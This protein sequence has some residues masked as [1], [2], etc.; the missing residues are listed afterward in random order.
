MSSAP[1]EVQ[2]SGVSLH[3]L[4]LV[5]V[6]TTTDFTCSLP[7]EAHFRLQFAISG[8]GTTAT[9]DAFAEIDEQRACILPPGQHSELH[10]RGGH[11]RLAL[12]I[13]PDAFKRKLSALMGG[14]PSGELVF[15]PS[16]DMTLE[17]SQSLL[18]TTLVL[19]ENVNWSSS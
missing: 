13:A 1:F 10:L 2:A 15:E 9:A 14:M 11:R 16:L 8:S 7:E 5:Y 19:A 17:R 18:Q 12:R 6:A 4:G 3:E